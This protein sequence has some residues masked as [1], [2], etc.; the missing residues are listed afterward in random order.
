[1]K[2]TFVLA[3]WV[4]LA[5]GVRSNAMLAYHLQK[6][7]HQVFVVSPQKA[8]PTIR[9][10]VSSFIKGEG[11]IETKR[12]GS[13]H[14]DGLDIP[15]QVLDHG[16]PV[17]DADVP[18][19]DIVV[20]CWWETAEWVANLSPSKGA[21]VYLIRH[22]EVHDYLPVERVKATYRLPLHK[23]TISKW[24]VD[25][26]GTEYGDHNVSLV[27]NSIDPNKYYAPPRSKQATPTVGMLYKTIKWKGCDI[28][29]KAFKLAKQAI[30]DLQMIAFGL[31]QPSSDL[32]LPP[33]TQYYQSPPQAK[34]KDIYAQ[35]DVWLCGSWAEGFHRPPLE[36]MACR[37]PIVST[38]VGGPIDRVINGVNGYLASLGDYKTLAEYLVKIITLSDTEWQKM[39][40]AAY[41][42]A[43]SYTWDDAAQLCEQAFHRAIERTQ[44]GDLVSYELSNKY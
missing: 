6:R 3:N 15:R 38:E 25:L 11:L 42:T 40:D 21:K 20:A 24:L 18:D 39:S 28:S 17:T 35:C 13:S 2:I 36:A 1:M 4:S 33:G 19:A 43:M 22:H 12:K 30:P 26:M 8:Q 5:G 27:C 37:C 34:I 10:Q 32:P 31:E 41:T 9:Q 16:S 29:L 23:I 7:G 14:F 44:T